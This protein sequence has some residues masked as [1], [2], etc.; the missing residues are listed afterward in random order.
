MPTLCCMVKI[1]SVTAF[2]CNFWS[3]STLF[4]VTLCSLINSLQYENGNIYWVV[5]KLIL[6]YHWI[7]LVISQNRYKIN[8]ITS[9]MS[10]TYFYDVPF[11]NKTSIL[12]LHKF[13][14]CVIYTILI[15]VLQIILVSNIEFVTSQ[16]CL[17]VCD[18]KNHREFVKSQIPIYDIIILILW[19]HK[20][21][22]VCILIN[23]TLPNK[24]PSRF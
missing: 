1:M 2:C 15:N 7:K 23:P 22:T 3:L 18:I 8:A 5:S 12:P 9:Q 4:Q 24:C 11:Y 20:I 13:G 14:K 16:Y 19:Y 17:V 21:I 6:W 10:P